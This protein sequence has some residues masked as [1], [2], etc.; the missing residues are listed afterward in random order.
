MVY[1]FTKEDGN[2][3]VVL[4]LHRSGDISSVRSQV[5]DVDIIICKGFLS[6]V[7]LTRQDYKDL[8]SYVKNITKD[9]DLFFE[10]IPS[11]KRHYKRMFEDLGYSVIEEKSGI[12]FDGHDAVFARIKLN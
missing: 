2:Y 11:A 3:D 5:D 4:T 6:R 12:T 10:V 7:R 9:T 1:G 8:F